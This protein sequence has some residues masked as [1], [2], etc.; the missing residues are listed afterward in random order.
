M[1]TCVGSTTWKLF[2]VFMSFIMSGWSISSSSMVIG[3]LPLGKSWLSRAGL[4]VYAWI[5]GKVT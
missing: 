4:L 2:M 5:V 3:P 1:T